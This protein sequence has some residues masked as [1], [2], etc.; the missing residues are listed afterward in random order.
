MT[1]CPHKSIE[2]IE[3]SCL[4][5]QLGSDMAEFP[6]YFVTQ[7]WALEPPAS[8][9]EMPC[10]DLELSDFEIPAARENRFTSTASCQD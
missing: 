8:H 5:L 9:Q 4:P 1:G 2:S 6:Y 10:I 3:L 7:G